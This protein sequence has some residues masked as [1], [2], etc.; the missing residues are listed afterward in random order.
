[1]ITDNG[2]TVIAMMWLVIALAAL[3]VGYDARKYRIPSTNKP[4]NI[5]NGAMASGLS[6][7]VVFWGTQFVFGIWV[8]SVLWLAVFMSWIVRR[9]RV[10]LGRSRTGQPIIPSPP[11]PPLP[12]LPVSEP[13]PP[14][15][16]SA[17]YG[18]ETLPAGKEQAILKGSCRHCRQHLEFDA[19]MAGQSIDCPHCNKQTMLVQ[20]LPPATAKHKP[21]ASSLPVGIP[22]RRHTQPTSSPQPAEQGLETELREIAKLKDQGLITESDYEE[23]KR[24]LL[25]L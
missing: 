22:V 1:M 17:P 24:K 13:L 6:G 18:E 11:L 9:S 21:D 8:A 7:P 12:A 16:P 15:P 23:K 5:N 25:G 10:L 3:W 2:A 19:Q 14:T 20:N 4:Y